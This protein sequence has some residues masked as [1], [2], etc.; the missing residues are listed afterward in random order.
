MSVAITT[1]DNT[2]IANDEGNIK[3]SNKVIVSIIIL[4]LT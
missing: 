2:E 4:P 1:N 3:E